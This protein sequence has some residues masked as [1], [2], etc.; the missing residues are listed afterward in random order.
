MTVTSRTALTA[1][2]T[3]GLRRRESCRRHGHAISA[4][5][6]IVETELSAVFAG[7]LAHS[8]GT[9]CGNFNLCVDDAR[10]GS[11]LHRAAQRSA[12]ILRLQRGQKCS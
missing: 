9:D 3:F 1:I 2:A 11:V 8:S 12:R 6:Q 7:G 10:A 5:K 4:G